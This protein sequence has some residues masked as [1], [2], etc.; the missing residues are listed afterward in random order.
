MSRNW[1]A[2]SSMV[3][4]FAV[5]C[6]GDSGGTPFVPPADVGIKFEDVLRPDVK[7]PEDIPPEC[8]PATF[9]A[10]CEGDS[11]IFCESDGT[12]GSET[13]PLGCEVEPLTVEARCVT[14]VCEPGEKRCEGSVTQIICKPSGTGW[15]SNICPSRASGTGLCIAAT[16]ECE[17]PGVCNAGELKC[18]G[19]YLKVCSA[20]E[21]GWEVKERCSYGCDNAEC[22][23]AL[24]APDALFCNPDDPTQIVQCNR[25][26][27]GWIYIQTCDQRCED[28]ECTQQTCVPGQY[29]CSGTSVQR[30]TAD[31][32]Y[33]TVDSC[34]YPCQLDGATA[35]CPICW[36]GRSFACTGETREECVPTEGLIERETC[37]GVDT[38][39]V[40][41]YCIPPVRFETGDDRHDELVRVVQ[42]IVDCWR[43]HE[44]SNTATL[45]GFL[46]T[47]DLSSS[48][49]D[50]ELT[51][52]FV[53]AE[54]D[55]LSPSDL[56][57]GSDDYD[58]ARDIFGCDSLFGDDKLDFDTSVQTGFE[59][60]YCIWYD[61]TF[62]DS[63]RVAECSAF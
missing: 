57:G 54:T 34:S 21:A 2:V 3:A 63:I 26:Q 33:E 61:P 49:G 20:D 51:D 37:D 12:Y 4:L 40:E 36:P 43:T 42:A 53:C 62:F 48:F 35:M 18:D 60:E 19:T 17:I 45:C 39:C 14:Q 15:F 46:D 10:I 56:A 5:G 52:G 11:R 16:G 8:D 58:L 6:G 23:E 27:T 28:G 1:L 24:C 59:D 55:G 31:N 29:R 50:E 22:L 41:G 30:C 13:C 47:D 7:A 25:S 32:Q 44:G 38:H 9:R